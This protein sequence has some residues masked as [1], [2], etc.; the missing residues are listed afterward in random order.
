M[1][2]ARSLSLA[3][4]VTAVALA[5]CAGNEPNVSSTSGLDKR[6]DIK[7]QP[8]PYK[9]GTGVVQSWAAAP[10]PAAGASGRV[11]PSG[12]GMLRL[13]IKMDDGKVQYVD[14]ESRDFPIGSRVQLTS[15]HIIRRP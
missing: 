11:D 3:A 5:G 1:K 14:T 13:G 4:L 12:S 7:A 6:P 10:S 2:A 15:D 9:A 8:M